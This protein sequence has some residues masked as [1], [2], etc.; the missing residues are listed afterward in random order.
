MIRAKIY[1]SVVR[2]SRLQGTDHIVKL[3]VK[4]PEAMIKIEP[5]LVI[6]GVVF[7][8]EKRGL[9]NAA[10]ETFELTTTAITASIA[11]LYGGKLCAALDRQH[12]R[13]I[14]DIKVLM[15]NEG[16]TKEIQI[17]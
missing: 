11:D 14:F 1:G 3:T 9:C 16:I 4:T 12:P 5:N 7:P 6:R 13:H 2:Q 10:E 17:L 8:Y 15:E